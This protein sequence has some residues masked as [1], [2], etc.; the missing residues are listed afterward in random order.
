MCTRDRLAE[1]PPHGRF[2]CAQLFFFVPKWYKTCKNTF[3]MQNKWKN[4]KKKFSLYVR[5]KKLR[6]IFD[7]K[8]FFSQNRLKIHQ[9]VQNH[10]KNEK[11]QK[12]KNFFFHLIWPKKNLEK[13][14]RKN[15]RPK[16]FFFSIDFLV[17]SNGKSN[18]KHFLL[19]GFF[20]YLP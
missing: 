17:F 15:F 19:L 1:A 5:K 13:F 4:W 11:K 6:K 16:K 9:N 18:S 10:E 12:K 8:F 14:F 3:R 2:L 20:R 7:Q